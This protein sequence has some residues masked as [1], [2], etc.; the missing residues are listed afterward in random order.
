MPAMIRAVVMLERRPIAYLS[1]ALNA[2]NLGLSI[3]EK[4]L[5]AL[6]TAVTRWRHYSEG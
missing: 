5:L 4:K 2:K 3:Y 6:V 1:Q